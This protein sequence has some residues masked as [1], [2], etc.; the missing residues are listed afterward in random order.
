MTYRHRW[1]QTSRS[2]FSREPPVFAIT[3]FQGNLSPEPSQGSCYADTLSGDLSEEQFSLSSDHGPE[4][5]NP[6]D[7][8]SV[9]N[10]TTRRTKGLGGLPDADRILSTS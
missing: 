3:R 2:F 9:A 5:T 6:P 7:Q 10:G 8:G 4:D 1:V